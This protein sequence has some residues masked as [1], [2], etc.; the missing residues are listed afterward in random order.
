MV[1][2]MKDHIGEE[3]D[4]HISGLKE[5]GIFVELDETHIEGL[6][7]LR[8]ISGDFYQFDEK[9]YQIYGRNTNKSFTL[10]DA[11]RIKIKR[12]DLGRRMLDFALVAKL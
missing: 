12:A 1:E 10:G 8:D 6:I 3:F 7:P 5:W 4:G 2:F 9:N 11:V